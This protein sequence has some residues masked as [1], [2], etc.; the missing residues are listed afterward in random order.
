MLKNIK[1][2]LTILLSIIPYL[3]TIISSYTFYQGDIITATY[4]ILSA[5]VYHQLGKK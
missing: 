1:D 3:S 4:F 5:L 2:L